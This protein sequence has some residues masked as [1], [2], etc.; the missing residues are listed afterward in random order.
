VF[1]FFS[2]R[3]GCLGS[4]AISAAVT[5]ALLFFLGILRF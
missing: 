4:L 1:L 5:L 2:S 3:F